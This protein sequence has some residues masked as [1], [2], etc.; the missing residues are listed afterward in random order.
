MIAFKTIRT[1]NRELMTLQ[2]NIRDV[3]Q[4][5]SDALIVEGVLIGPVTIGTSPTTIPH[6]LNRMP[7]GWIPSRKK[8]LGDIFEISI[9]ANNLTLQSSVAVTTFLWVF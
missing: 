3:L 6:T 1:Q 4:P 7:L 5:I 8:G 9:N 2:D